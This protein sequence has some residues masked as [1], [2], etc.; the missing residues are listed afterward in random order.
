MAA[1]AGMKPDIVLDQALSAEEGTGFNF[2]TGEIVDLKESGIIDPV[3][4]TRCA[5]QNS[6]SAIGTLITTSHAII[7]E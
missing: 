5:L 1:N 4:V 3:K 6:V 7:D 2:S